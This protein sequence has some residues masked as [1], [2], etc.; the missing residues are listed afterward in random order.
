MFACLGQTPRRLED[1]CQTLHIAERPAAALLNV[2]VSASLVL[3]QGEF[4][5][6][7]PLAKD[8]LLEASPTYFGDVFDLDL[9]DPIS[10]AGIEKAVLSNAQQVYGGGDWV[11]SRRKAG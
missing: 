5:A 11:Q 6:L 3:K 8:Y 10:F 4:Y 9:A 7:T 2:S 1:I